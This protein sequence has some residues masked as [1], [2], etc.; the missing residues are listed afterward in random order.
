MMSSTISGTIYVNAP[1]MV[2]AERE[3]GQEEGFKAL[4]NPRILAYHA[5][6]MLR[7][8]SDEVAWCSA[9][10]NWC[11]REAGIAGTNS[12][13]AT[14]WLHWGKTSVPKVGAITVVRRV[15]GESHVAFLVAEEKTH[16]QLLG[17]NQGDKVKLS[18][19]PKS[20]YVVLG[21]RW[22]EQNK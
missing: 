11:L 18:S 9:F 21:Y 8:T 4:N 15:T 22:P 3:I 7:A 6:T 17:G 16:Y 5:T 20:Q 19:Y 2:V 13:S 10:V 14:S 12:A 1:W